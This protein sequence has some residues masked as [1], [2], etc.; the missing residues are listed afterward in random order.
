[1]TAL[2]IILAVVVVAL[3][4]LLIV[5]FASKKKKQQQAAAGAESDVPQGGDE[6][7]ILFHEADAKLAA[8]AAKARVGELPVFLL[9]GE[10]GSTKTSVMVNSGV[11]PELLSGLV[12]QANAIAPTRAANLWFAKGAVFVEAGGALPADA[13]KWGRLVKALRPRTSTMRGQPQ[14][15]RA[16]VVFFD[17][18]NFTKPG[19]TEH[20]TNLARQLRARLGEISQG[21]G[22][23]LPVYVLFAKMDRVPFFL[24]YVRNLS[25][26]EA[27][28]VL[29]VTLPL[30]PQNAG[31]YGEQE[32]AR[33]TGEFERLF[34]ALADGRP[35]F[36]ARESDATKLPGAYEFPREFRKVRTAAVQ[37]LVDLCRPSQLTVGPFLRGFYFTGVRPVII[38]EAAPVAAAP[39][40]DQ[41]K[42][43]H[44]TSIFS[45]A[46]RQQMQQA[47]QQLVTRK[48]P[49][50][51]FLSQL[52]H[53]VFLADRSAMGA[54][55][56][57]IK[58]SSA[59]RILF[60][61]AAAVC[62]LL[63]I[64]FLISFF[65]N[66]SLEARVHEAA[67]GTAFGSAASS[68]LASLDQLRRLEDLR[69][70]LG[71]LG[72][73]HKEGAPLH[74]RWGLFVGE[75]LYTEARR[76]Y[77]D[78]F[79]QILFFQTQSAILQNLRALPSTPG[80]EYGPTYD[81]LKAYLITT[82][83]PDKSTRQFLTP[84]MMRWWTNNRTVD[85]DRQQLAQKQFDFYADTLQEGNPFSKENDA[86]TIDRTRRYLAQFAGTD[87]VYAFMMA[88]AGRNNPPINFNRQFAGSNQVV[89]ETHEVAG[90]FS[91]GGFKY[92]KDAI[93]HADRY[94]SGEQWVL[95]NQ[96][97]ASIDRAQLD[98]D[99]KARYYG[100]FVKEWRTYVESGN[101]VRYAN[102][103]DASQKLTQLSGNQSFLLM[104]LA[105]ASQN[106]AVDD[107]N[108][109]N[110]FQP[111]QAVVPP[112][113]TDRLIAPPNQPYMNALVTLQSSLD[114]I[115]NRP[116]PPDDAAAAQTLQNA[117]QAK[118]VT[119]QIA[120]TFRIDSE[121]HLDAGVQKLLEQPI[122]YVEGMLRALGPAELNAKGKAFCATFR[123]TMVKYPFNPNS[124]ADATLAEV[125]GLFRK[126]DGALWMFYDQN[127]Q[128]LL[129]KQGDQY[130]AASAGSVM[131]NPA[132]V[133][134]FNA[135]AR[136]SDAIYAGG[137]QD[138]HV[139][140]TLTP[141]P[142]EGIQST[143]LDLDGQA[144]RYSGKPA[145]MQFTWQG[146]GTHDAKAT[147]KF[148]NGPDL[149][150][151]SNDG[152]WAVFR[153]FGK[154]ERRQPAGS[155]ES[156]EWV[157]RIGKDPV[158]LPSG[159]AL[160]VRFT[161]DM[162]GDPPVFQRD[163]FARMGCVAD[164]AR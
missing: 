82:S 30:A 95:G 10:P 105:L 146:G 103:K 38:N 39:T 41:D 15:P 100:D 147:V 52:F 111:V 70:A 50:W 129:V 29:G 76:V 96:A 19:A 83:N 22:I 138:P 37:F 58:T 126:P 92:M 85:P 35:E 16:A 112:G 66:R 71:T 119:R 151:S 125:N 13:T 28:Q 128:K 124:T 56:A 115:A 46:Q 21:L 114:A 117:A 137:A 23:N 11:D 64:A 78:R 90:A 153:F 163:F 77:F 91:K 148:G 12:Y 4:V 99:L 131:P 156:L 42:A 36:L 55:S 101:V 51:L 160:T 33:L 75:P 54:S 150:W 20:A 17:C 24:D 79:R 158:T 7:G 136:F 88:E 130:T 43:A 53:G 18:E 97:G 94:F 14:A 34:H 87:R 135:A 106:T 8:S 68:D 47:P 157:I 161:L 69:Q 5:W 61:A 139:K 110:I 74:Y 31:V 102:L 162:N 132:F 149:T 60:A 40:P 45:A 145:P 123:T 49:Q 59:R 152:L 144:L 164:I 80:P 142:T 81:A 48:V 89:V 155:G 122:T 57:S 67:Q 127:L 107:P 65:S 133:T 141:E 140:Y 2:Y 116:G 104:L 9:L 108:V 73:Y 6:I 143:N 120:Q 63:S 62:V 1:M 159:K 32:T 109:A 86:A 27:G 84:V 3:I 26:E 154:A 93:A 134:F 118:V 25:N 44:A 72:T 98:K 121:G 113:S